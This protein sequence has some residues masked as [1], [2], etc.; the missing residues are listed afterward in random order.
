MKGWDMGDRAG[1]DVQDEAGVRRVTH[2][3][4]PSDSADL[5]DHGAGFHPQLSRKLELTVVETSVAVPHV[6]VVPP[7]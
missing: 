1:V 2:G 6:L 4:L 3:R 5:G 7:V